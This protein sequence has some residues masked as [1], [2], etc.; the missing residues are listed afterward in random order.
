MFVTDFRYV[1]QA[2]DEVDPSFERRRASQ[3]LLDAIPDALPHG[4]VRLGFE[5]AHM[6]VRQHGRLRE[7][8]R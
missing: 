8:L 2:A 4:T 1:E 3:D 7:L 6:S 5:D